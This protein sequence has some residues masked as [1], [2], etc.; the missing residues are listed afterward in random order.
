M[1]DFQQ[2]YEP[3]LFK[4]DP[5]DAEIARLTADRDRLRERVAILEAELRVAYKLPA[6]I[7]KA[8]DEMP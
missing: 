1:G 3:W 5:R 6:A 8:I 7:N 4:P 2:E